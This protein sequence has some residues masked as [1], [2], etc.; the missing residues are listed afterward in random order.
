MDKGIGFSRTI[1]LDWLDVTASLCIQNIEPLTI[2]QRLAETISGTVTGIDAQRKTIDVLSAIWVKTEKTAPSIRQ[3][4][5]A[6][7]PTLSTSE[8]RLWLHYGM[9]L[10]CY[11]IFR[12]VVA[13]IGQIS[14][15]EE[16]IT[17]K[18]IK[19]RIAGEYG[20][21]GALDR[22][23]ERIIASLTNWGALANTDQVKKYRIVSHH[24][25]A[26]EELQSWLLTCALTAHP[27]EAIPFDDLVHLPELYPFKINIG[28]D[29]L[30]RDARFEVQRQG[31]GLEMVTTNC[32]AK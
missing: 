28:V 1:T 2:R 30:R 29:T 3:E 24:F 21:L 13:A 25:S 15:A 27:S 26:A 22:S 7:F 18:M 10:V 31:G 20:H 6:L 17:R 9:T 11:P 23:V 4:A 32:R 12:K 14:R 5:L 8:E 16:I 19:D